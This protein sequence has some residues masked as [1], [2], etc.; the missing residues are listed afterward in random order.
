MSM[1][2]GKHLTFINSMQHMDS[3]LVKNE[4]ENDF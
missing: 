1:L 4:S 3:I 2:L